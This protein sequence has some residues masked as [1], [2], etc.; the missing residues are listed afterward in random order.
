M[1]RRKFRQRGFTLIELVFVIAI[2]TIL[3]SMFLP[4]AIEKITQTDESVAD[5]SVQEIAAGLTSFYD[6]L[7][8]FPAC[9]AGPGGTE[10]N[11]SPMSGTTND[12]VFLA[13]GDGFDDIS[14]QYPATAAGPGEWDLTV[15]DEL[16]EE[17]NNGANHLVV[18]DPIRGVAASIEGAEDYELKTSTNKRRWR[19]PY[20]ARVNADSWGSAFIAYVGSMEKNGTLVTGGGVGDSGWILSAGPDN[21]LDTLPSSASLLNDD[22]GFIFHT[23]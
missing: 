11:C 9:G 12:L 21:T 19:G 6:N 13:F 7:R 20:L 18:N 16:D 2:I 1:N 22:R 23:D 15:N 14:A 8:H 3:V 10:T 17:R 5:I 4:L